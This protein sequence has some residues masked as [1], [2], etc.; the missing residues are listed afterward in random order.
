MRAPTTTESPITIAGRMRQVSWTDGVRQASPKIARLLEKPFAEKALDFEDGLQLSQAEGP[1]LI[2]LLKV[3][4]E[5][6]RQTVGDAITFVINRNLNFTNICTV[7]CAFCGFSRG[8][9]SPDAYFHSHETLVEKAVEAA[10][11]G[12]TEVCIQGGLPR[13]LSAYY[14]RDLLRTIRTALPQIH[15]HA[16]SPMEI[17]NGVERTA[18]P[19]RD[20]LLL[21]KDA[22]LG[23]IPGTAAEILDDEVRSTLSPNKLKVAQWIEII[24]AAHALGIPTT[25]TMMYGH[26]EGPEHWVRHMLL[27]RQIQ[28]ETHGF[29]EFVPLGFI[30]SKTRLYR[31]GEARAGSSLKEHLK[32]HALARLLLHGHI[33]NI[34]VSWVKMG[35]DH[36]LACLE[37]GANDFGGTLMEESISKSAGAT[38][39]ESVSPDEFIALIRSISRTPA[40]RTTTYRIRRTFEGGTEAAPSCRLN[41]AI[42]STRH[43]GA[44]YW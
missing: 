19:L 12:A 24:R 17:A 34:Q 36:S 40:E 8:P 35:F 7:G 26:V 13:E 42:S 5:L 10:R 37:A 39:G 3:A 18:L 23:S 43:A 2:A 30:H 32:V 41:H 21:L 27:L 38:F 28:S 29:T 22:G 16:F 9:H 25:S 44:D 33:R 1:D 15:I 14:Y 4:N 6:R 11:L 31:I 20:Y